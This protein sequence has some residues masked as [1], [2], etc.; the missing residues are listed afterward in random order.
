ML[1]RYC[2]MSLLCLLLIACGDKGTQAD[3]LASVNAGLDQQLYAGATLNLS[4]KGDPPGGDFSWHQLSGP[5]LADFPFSGATISIPLPDDLPESRLIFEVRYTLSDGRLLRDRVQVDVMRPVSAPVALVQ[6]GLAD[7]NYATTGQSIQL[8]ASDS[9]DPEGQALSFLWQQVAGP[10]A[11]LQQPINQPVLLLKAPLLA[12]DSEFRFELF[13]Q[14][15]AGLS[16]A[17]EVVLLVQGNAA[18]IYADAG[19]DR[20]VLEFHT[21][22]LDGSN[23]ASLRSAVD[24]HWTQLTGA[25]VQLMD[26]KACHT[27]FV[28]PDSRQHPELRFQLQVQ[29]STGAQA[30]DEV[31]LTVL[32]SG[33]HYRVDTGQSQCYD[34]LDQIACDDQAYP[35]QD[36]DFG[37]D[38]IAALLNKTGV[39][40][41]GFDFSKLDSHGDE[42]PRDAADFSCVRDNVTGLIWE[43]KE[44]AAASVASAS[45]RAASNY[46]S[47]TSEGEGHA[48]NLGEAAPALDGCPDLN[49]CGTQAYVAAVNAALYCGGGNWRL[50]TVAELNTL[51]DFGADKALDPALF[52][53]EPEPALLGHLYYWTVQSSAEGGGAHAAWVIDMRDGNDNSLPKRADSR[54]FVRLVRSP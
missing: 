16:D 26:A 31:V 29:D 37:R 10:V 43:V 1:N 12:D 46:Y 39:G 34:G 19:L 44:P 45:L 15:E 4:A 47:W 18:G 24:C 27:N 40:R 42:L 7:G 38:A 23:S 52:R 49:N 30:S 2:L 51:V 32:S 41:A 13:V 53:H 54:A 33:L 3:D 17:L 9:F 20:T 6:V 48:G 8:D 28:V 22:W 35:R 5:A 25:P 21:S 11:W 14:N 36:A 50:P